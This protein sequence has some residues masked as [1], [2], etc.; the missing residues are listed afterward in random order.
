[1]RDSRRSRTTTVSGVA[2]TKSSFSRLRPPTSVAKARLT[3]SVLLVS[4][5]RTCQ[6]S[7][8]YGDDSRVKALKRDRYGRAGFDPSERSLYAVDAEM[9]VGDS[10]GQATREIVATSA[11][12]RWA[13]SPGCPYCGVVGAG[14]G[15][16]AMDWLSGRSPPVRNGDPV[17]SFS[18]PPDPISNAAAGSCPGSRRR[19]PGRPV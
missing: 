3:R 10:V 2:P 11:Y 18:V 13:L 15:R 12:L 17:A 8:A 16:T 4:V 19:R 5:Q 6:L 7:P 9:T 14:T 1:M